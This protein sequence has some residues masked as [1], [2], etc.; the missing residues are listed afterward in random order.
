MDGHRERNPTHLADE[1]AHVG[2]ADFAEFYRRHAADVYRF[3]LYLTREPADAED[4]TSETFVRVWASADRVESA[5]VTGY[6]F[7]IARNL[8]VQSSQR[9][10]KYRHVGLEGDLPDPRP[11][12]LALAEARSEA[13]AFHDRLLLLPDVDRAALLLRAI[14]QLPYE[15]IARRL[16]ISVSSAKV[17]VHRAR[18]ALAAFR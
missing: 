3:A 1:P 6:L 9:R 14:D 18:L 15:Q 7:T 5:T 12:P 17:K 16:G 13:G 11:D 10:V 4:I 2:I 8:Y